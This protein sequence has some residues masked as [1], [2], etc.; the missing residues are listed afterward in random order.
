MVGWPKQATSRFDL[1]QGLRSEPLS[2]TPCTKD[3]VRRLRMRLWIEVRTER[4]GRELDCMLSRSC[5]LQEGVTPEENLE[6]LR[7][8]L[9]EGPAKHAVHPS[10]VRQPV[11]P[12]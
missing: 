4:G 9:P 7:H 2:P 5:G 1:T 11:L 8:K 6:A 12:L 3:R 10:Q